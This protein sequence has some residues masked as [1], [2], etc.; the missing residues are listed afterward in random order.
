[1]ADQEEKTTRNIFKVEWLTIVLIFVIAFTT[2]YFY[3]RDRLADSQE[4]VTVTE[5]PAVES[6]Q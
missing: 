3:T 6:A 5:N 1:M 4:E 2:G